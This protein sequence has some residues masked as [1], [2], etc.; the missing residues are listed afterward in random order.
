MR[1]DGRAQQNVEHSVINTHKFAKVV[2]AAWEPSLA[3]RQASATTTSDAC[4]AVVTSAFSTNANLFCGGWFAQQNASTAYIAPAFQAACTAVGG[5]ASQ[6][7]SACSNLGYTSPTPTTA[8]PTSATPT[9]GMDNCVSAIQTAFAANAP[10]FCNGW[11]NA[12][13]TGFIAPVFQTACA[14]SSYARITSACALITS[15]PSVAVT[16]A[17]ATPTG[18]Y[19][20]CYTVVTSAFPNNY[21]QFCAGW[22]LA[23][24][25]AYV[26]PAFQTSC[27]GNSYSRISSVCSNLTYTPP[28]PTTAP[29]A[30]PTGGLDN[31]YTAVTSAFPSNYAAFCYGWNGAGTTAFV[32][33]SFQTS[34]AGN[35]Y[36]RIS[37]VCSVLTSTVVTATPTPTAASTPVGGM[38][39]CVS[40]VMT[41]FPTNANLFCAGWQANNNTAGYLGPAFVTSCAGNPY[42]RLSSACTQLGYAPAVATPTPTTSATPTGG[43][44]NCV[45]AIQTAFP[46]NANLFCAGWQST[47]NTSGFVAPAFQTSCAGNSYSRMSSACTQLGYGPATATPTPT[48]SATPIGG[49]D[50]CVSAIQTAFPTNA[51]L[52]CAGWQST[53]NTS[54]FVAP[55]FQTSCA[56]NS[57]S[58]MSSACTQLGYAPVTPVATTATPTGG[59]DNCVTAIQ[60][61]FPTNANLFCAGWQST[62]NTSGF[63][64]PALQTSCAGNS[65][66]RLSSAC[67]QLGYAPVTPVATTATPTGGMDNCVTA[68]QSAFPTNANLFCAGWQSTN[69][70]SGFVAPALQTSCAGNSFSRLSSA[71]TQLGYAPATP[72]ATTATPTGGMDNCVTAIQS[73]FATNTGLFCAGFT[74]GGFIAP[75][76]QTSCAGNSVSRISSACS[77]L[78]YT[79][80]PLS[81]IHI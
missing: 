31:C 39:N 68:I 26:G 59:M 77:Q 64:A 57:F 27:A 1:T 65:F 50:N 5:A 49:M 73:A 75:A 17:P 9:G 7:S 6:L 3:K 43:M 52:F 48:T 16:T 37:S 69:N 40:A 44:D 12:G 21:G 45:S 13:T 56:G 15:T 35:S 28:A 33:G 30:T 41:A 20:A 8:V 55:A 46:T 53:N 78:T 62:N 25:T 79:P 10:L 32:A 74:S 24:T 4:V 66:S 67:T 58:R 42:S 23:G 54:G 36:S 76:F 38:D 2:D 71:C 51:N 60:S 47:N 11:G 18:G 22:N 63:V 34:C 61:A 70:T 81:L 19:D 29:L 80:P 14:G 72:V